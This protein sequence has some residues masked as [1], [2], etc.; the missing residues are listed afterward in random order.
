MPRAGEQSQEDTGLPRGSF[1][2]SAWDRRGD[3]ASPHRCQPV[4][5]HRRLHQL[6]RNQCR[7]RASAPEGGSEQSSQML[8]SLQVVLRRPLLLSAGGTE[9]SGV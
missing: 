8:I 5:R 6:R 3:A 1:S 9:T 4:S 7:E 2:S